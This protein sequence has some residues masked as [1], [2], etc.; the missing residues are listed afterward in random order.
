MTVMFATE[1]EDC[2]FVM[3]RKKSLILFIKIIRDIIS[4]LCFGISV[5]VM[6]LKPSHYGPV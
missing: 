3:E 2:S 4:L 6:G 1:V 5:K